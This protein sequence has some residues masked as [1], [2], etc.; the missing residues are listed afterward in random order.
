[1]GGRRRRAGMVR[2]TPSRS[3]ALVALAESRPELELVRATSLDAL[4][5]HPAAR[6]VH[7]RR[8]PQLLHRQRGAAAHRRARPRRRL[9]LLLF[10]DVC[11][12]H[13]RRDDY[14]DARA[15]PRRAPPADRAS[16]GRSVPRRGRACARGGLLYKWP[17]AREGGPRNG[18]LTA[19]EDFVEGRDG[20]RLAIVPAFFGLGV[21]WSRDAPYADALAEILDPWDRNPLLER[22][23]A[24]R[25]LHLRRQRDQAQA[26]WCARAQRAQGRPAA[27]AA[28]V[29]AFA[30]AER[31]SRLR[32][33][34]GVATDS[35]A[36]PRTRS[37]RAAADVRALTRAVSPSAA[38]PQRLRR[39]DPA[40][41]LGHPPADA[42]CSARSP[43][44]RAPRPAARRRPPGA[45][46]ARR[47]GLGPPRA[48]LPVAAAPRRRP[49]IRPSHFSATRMCASIQVSGSPISS[50]E[51]WWMTL[52]SAVTTLRPASRTCRQKSKS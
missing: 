52:K 23:E 27:A 35:S 22:L 49:G 37:A 24:N 39:V 19:V 4:P 14:F 21:V 50:S 40:Q 32:Q 43:S 6:R 30:L 48:L 26:A 11:W 16:G 36:S 17:A 28:R 5:T 34:A 38:R 29:G 15:D 25:V 51:W 1:M 12:P 44:V 10:H 18:V 7:H 2:S 45:R 33:R 42:R 9:P 47:L 20:L 31:L 41:R 8:R 13:A 3:P 46:A